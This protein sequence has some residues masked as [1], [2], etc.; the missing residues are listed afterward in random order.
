MTGP[1]I[2]V[3]ICVLFLI[4]AIIFYLIFIRQWKQP[5][6][7]SCTKNSDCEEGLFCGGGGICNRGIPADRNEDCLRD[8]DCIFG[9]N[10]IDYICMNLLYK[11]IQIYNSNKYLN[12]NKNGFLLSKTPQV[13]LIDNSSYIYSKQNSNKSIGY[14]SKNRLY[15]YTDQSFSNVQYEIINDANT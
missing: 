4:I 2:I 3:V 6:G 12:Y 13:F 1:N 15:S 14:Y 7:Y 10:C 11:E 8:R 5:E 9:L